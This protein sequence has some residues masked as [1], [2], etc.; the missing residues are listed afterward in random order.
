MLFWKT[1]NRIEP[2]RE[3]YSKIKEYYIG[4]VD[5]QIPM[6]LLNEIISKVTDRI[7][8]DYKR[9]WKQYP[10]SRKRYSTLKMDDIENP[11]I[12]YLITDFL[13]NRKLV[14]SRNFLKILFKM[15]DEEFDKYLDQKDWYETK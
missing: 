2:K 7:Y 14:E 15:N 6:E 4:I 9:F 3:F 11:F 1:E 13:E 8:S 5:N 12:H 10:K